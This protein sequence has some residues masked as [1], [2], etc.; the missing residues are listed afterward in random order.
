M[1][2]SQRAGDVVSALPVRP[3]VARSLAVVAAPAGRA[4]SLTREEA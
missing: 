2:R 1:S 4:P 3:D